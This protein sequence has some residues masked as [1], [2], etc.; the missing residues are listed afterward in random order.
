M[1]PLIGITTYEPNARLHYELPAVYAEAVR[2]AGG[3]PVLIPP[4]EVQLDALLA[5]L[6]GLILSGG[7]DVDPAY[8]GGVNHP[9]V[10]NIHRERDEME[11]ALARLVVAQ[12]FPTL[13]ICRGVQVL[14]V[15]L[16]GTLIEHIPDEPF[17]TLAHHRTETNADLAL[18]DIAVTPDSRLAQ[19]MGATHL[20]LETWHHQALRA[21]APTL[22][23]VAV[24]PDGIVEA[25]E[26]SDHPFLL[27]V[28]WHPERAA[29]SLP[30]QRRLFEALIAAARDK[31]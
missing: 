12:D 21:V 3:I 25:V 13:C 5:R 14:N 2:L 4:G 1:T 29:A 8:Y 27:G 17:T 15:A 22:N 23:T 20:H 19:V 16:G 6:D 24:A 10:F 28:Q 30:T 26:K 18:H 9:K 7:D 11:I 31:D